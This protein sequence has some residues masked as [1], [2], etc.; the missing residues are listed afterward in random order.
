[1]ENNMKNKP[2]ESSSQKESRKYL[3]LSLLEYLLS[4]G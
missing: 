1:M 4:L 2:L 3:E